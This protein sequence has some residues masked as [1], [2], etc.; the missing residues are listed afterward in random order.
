MSP[1]PVQYNRS[2]LLLGEAFKLEPGLR[3]KFQILYK[4]SHSMYFHFH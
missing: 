3:E 4:V 1:L 2:A